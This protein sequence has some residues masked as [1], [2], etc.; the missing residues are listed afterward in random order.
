MRG[1][2]R[3]PLAVGFPAVLVFMSKVVSLIFTLRTTTRFGRGVVFTK[4][5]GPRAKEGATVCRG[6]R[7]RFSGLLLRVLVEGA[8]EEGGDSLSAV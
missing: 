4:S 3:F 6:R 7:L 1:G 8:A 2:L 5:S